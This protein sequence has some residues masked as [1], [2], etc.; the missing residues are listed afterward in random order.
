MEPLGPNV[1][2]TTSLTLVTPALQFLSEKSC[3]G[4]GS[5]KFNMLMKSNHRI[6]VGAESRNGKVSLYEAPVTETRAQILGAVT[7]LV[8]QENGE[9]YKE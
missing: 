2:K 5:L 1:V 6:S 8:N 3:P 4:E 9:N 7:T